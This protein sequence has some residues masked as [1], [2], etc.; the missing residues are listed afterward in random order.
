MRVCM[1]CLETNHTILFA[2]AISH[3]G[4]FSDIIYSKETYTIDCSLDL[5]WGYLKWDTAQK[6]LA[7]HPL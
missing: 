5:S 4:Q 2:R 3:L 6:K 7:W 1:S